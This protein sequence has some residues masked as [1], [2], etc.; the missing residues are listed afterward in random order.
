VT[1]TTLERSPAARTHR[2]VLDALGRSR[3]A[4]DRTS[5]RSPPTRSAP[6]ETRRRQPHLRGRLAEGSS[7]E[8]AKGCG[9][10]EPKSYREIHVLDVSE[11][12]IPVTL[13]DTGD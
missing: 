7:V 11:P 4:G 9:E 3:P 5:V 2:H 8:R 6:G 13:P 10:P 1:L 12:S